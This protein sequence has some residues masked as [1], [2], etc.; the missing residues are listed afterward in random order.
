MSSITSLLKLLLTG[1]FALSIGCASVPPYDYTAFRNHRPRSILVLPPLNQSIDVN[2]SYNYL[3]TISRPLAECGYY[4]FPVAVVDQY[5]KENGLP[6]PDEMHG[7]ALKKIREIIGA[8]AVL[9]VTIEEWGQKY[10]VLDS[11]T[12]IKANARLIDT[13]SGAE[14][15]QA[16]EDVSKSAQSNTGNADPLAS[17]LAMA[18]IQMIAHKLDMTHDLAK[19]ANQD[20]IFNSHHGLLGGP[21]LPPQ[22]NGHCG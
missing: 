22:K 16:T 4:V 7:V 8:D 2:A 11:I 18:V 1:L 6:S 10:A 5:M 13:K 3:S 21:Y 9:Y 20:M 14:I 12:K 19:T 17:M 15:W